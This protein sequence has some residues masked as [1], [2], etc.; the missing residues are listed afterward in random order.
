MAFHVI[1]MLFLC[2]CFGDFRWLLQLVARLLL[3]VISQMVD[4]VWLDCCFD[5]QM[6]GR[7]LLS[8]CYVI[9]CVY[10]EFAR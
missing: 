4:R 10:H 9:P 5:F 6:V 3:Y 1:G 8:V 2:G 7:V